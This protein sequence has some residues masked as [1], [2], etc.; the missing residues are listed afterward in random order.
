MQTWS[1]KAL[2]NENFSGQSD[3][4]IDNC[5][6][7][8]KEHSQKSYFP[9]KELDEM[10]RTKLNRIVDVN[11]NIIDSNTHLILN[12]CYQYNNQVPNFHPILKGNSPEIDHIFPKS[13]MIRKYKYPSDLVNNIGNY[14][15]L[16]KIFNGKK[17]DEMPKDFFRDALK[18]QPEFYQRNL[19]PSDERLHNPESFKEF[20]ET[21]RQLIFETVKRVLVY[22]DTAAQVGPF[23]SG[24]SGDALAESD[25]AKPTTRQPTL[26]PEFWPRD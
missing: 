9:Y 18:I 16:E 8:I 19:I 13:K 24:P 7:V 12:L 2:L 25:Q 23:A 1:Y 3:R 26:E 6:D 21:R 4:A 10:L 22:R 11:E 17:T 20:V 5:T 15:F 14:M